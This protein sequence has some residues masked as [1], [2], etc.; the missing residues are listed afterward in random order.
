MLA[1]IIHFIPHR[2]LEC[3]QSAADT[4]RPWAGRRAANQCGTQGDG[5]RK[6]GPLQS[7]PDDLNQPRELL[8]VL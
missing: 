3:E 2:K 7:V 4:L 8:P 6:R 1:A 5:P